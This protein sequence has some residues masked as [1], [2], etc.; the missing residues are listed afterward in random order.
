LSM[1]FLI[2]SEGDWRYSI[3]SG[4][5]GAGVVL[6]HGLTLIM[7][8][9][10]LISYGAFTYLVSCREDPLKRRKLAKCLLVAVGLSAILPSYWLYYL[11]DHG[12]Y[13]TIP[14]ST[15]M[16]LK[17]YP[18]KLGLFQLAF[19][20]V[21]VGA[22]YCRRGRSELFTLAMYGALFLLTTSF[23]WVLPTRYIE[24]L[25][26]PVSILAGLGLKEAMSS[27]REVMVI[28]FV[29]IFLVTLA[30]PLDYMDSIAPLVYENEESSFLWLRDNAV[31]DG[32]I[33]TGWFFASVSAAI[34][35][36]IPIKGSYY[37]GSFNYLAR[38]NDTNDFYNGDMSVLD[39]Y[40]IRVVYVGRKERYD[41]EVSLLDGRDSLNKLY[42]CDENAFYSV[43]AKP[44]N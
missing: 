14:E 17:D 15:A 20:F 4:I 39:K 22:A 27:K 24:F 8:A 21:G 35:L 31:V 18:S 38:T 6:T 13:S 10:L 5:M 40:D 34:S 2:K 43:D 12:V 7:F 29:G 1:I 23:F 19:S 41:Y 16:A 44:Y 25:A 9:V 36:K 33:I 3:L 42:S 28:G 30:A 11:F 32:Q 37:S 26:I